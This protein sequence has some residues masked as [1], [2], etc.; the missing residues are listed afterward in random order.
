MR[1]AFTKMHGLGNDFVVVDLRGADSDL[2][3]AATNAQRIRE[4]ADRR[5]GIGFDQW[6]TIGQPSGEHLADYRVFN[7]DGGEVEQCGNGARCIAAWLAQATGA[8]PGSPLALGSR[9]GDVMAQVDAAGQVTTTLMPPRFE[10]ADIPL[11]ADARADQ[12]ALG[13]LSFAAVSVGNP[14]C[15]IY[16]DD[17]VAAAPLLEIAE[18]VD[19]SGRFPEGVNVGLAQVTGPDRIDLRVRERG[20]GETR[21]CGTG[22]AA[23][24]VIGLRDGRV[25]GPVNVQLAG[26]TLVVDWRPS[27][28]GIAISGPA[29]TAYEG[30]VTL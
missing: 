28:G 16:L 20:V 17:A 6:L 26:G 18:S 12:Y 27:G 13:D 19:A 8:Q 15:V 22:A 3:E 11:T 21:A 1:M 23:A 4:L 25:S 2:I 29:Q 9:G 5:T 24:A 7:A 30:Y 14:H 10:P